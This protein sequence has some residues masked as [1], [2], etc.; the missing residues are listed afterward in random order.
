MSSM[1][2]N[3]I[4]KYLLMLDGKHTTNQIIQEH[5]DYLIKNNII[6]KQKMTFYI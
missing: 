1:N 3:D 2:D 6:L 5:I 4:I